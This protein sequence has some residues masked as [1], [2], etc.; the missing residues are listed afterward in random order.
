MSELRTLLLTDIV[1]STALAARLGDADAAALGAA[2]DRVARDLL[3]AWRGRE[4]DKTDGMLMLFDRASDA[5]GCAL[6]YHDALGALPTPIAARAAIH[7]AAIELRANAAH[8]VALGA[9]PLEV[10][11]IAK[12]IAARVM[13]IANGGQTLL[14]AQAR[15]ALGEASA[16]TQDWRVQS[17]GHWRLKGIVDP[18]ELFEVGGAHA[19]FV[20]PPDSAK[21]YRV[22]RRRELWLP[23]RE[24]RHT[25]PAERDDFIGR[26]DALAELVRRLDSG[27]RLVSV[28][29][30]GGS[31]KTRLVTRFAWTWLGEYPG[32]VW[33]CDLSQSR[34]VEGIAHAVAQGLEVRLG[35]DDPV[36]QLGHAIAGR[37]ACLVILDN[38]EQVARHADETLG[39]W[40]DRAADA[41]FVVTTREVLGLAGETTF[42]LAPLPA[43]DATALFVRRAKAARSDFLP[44]ADDE[45]AIPQLVK[46]LDGLPLAIELAAARVRVMPPRAL[47][48][49]M[50]QRFKLLAAAGARHDRQATLRAAFDASWELLTP[51]EKSA[52]AQLSV[53]EGGFSIEAAEAVVDLA[54][55]DAG[56]HWALDVLQSLHDKSFVRS[57]A[58]TRMELLTSVQEYAA[59]HLRTPG[60]FAGSGPVA[61]AAAQARH[62]AHFAAIDTRSVTA[63]H[64]VELD[65]LVQACRRAVASGN[66]DLAVAVLERAWIALELHGPFSA[67]ASLANLVAGLPGSAAQVQARASRVLGAALYAAG[68]PAAA[69]RHFETALRAD[70]DAI[71]AQLNVDLGKI[72][73]GD[74]ELDAA[75]ERFSCA[76]AAAR[77]SGARLVECAALNGLGSICTDQGR[78]DEARAHYKSA[79]RI[80]RD[81]GD[82][83][84]EGGLHGNL[85]NV[86]AV[87][88][89][90]DAAQADYERSL[91]AARETGDRRWEG[92][93][94]SN[95][96]LLNYERG[97]AADA[98]QQFEA[99]LQI[100]REIGHRR[101]EGVALCN[102]GIARQAIGDLATARFDF[103]AAVALARAIG[104]RQ[105]LGQ[106]LGY[107]GLLLARQGEFGAARERLDDG[108]AILRQISS[109]VDLGLLLCARAEAEHLAGDV[110]AA[111]N[112]IGEAAAIAA[113]IG[114][115]S[116]ID[117]ELARTLDRVRALVAAARGGP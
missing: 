42:A 41:R 48:A 71:E 14:T 58:D 28:L 36:V 60:R 77:R 49:R 19:P 115:E 9:K 27:V 26:Q 69:K 110:S 1:D 24:I 63:G 50:D 94:L 54:A 10:D 97:R 107:L 31:G 11:G 39:R 75:N 30:V 56:T 18:V 66:A 79:L 55:D 21:A 32:G 35:R 33:F 109:H 81:A 40:L 46:L 95:L 70:G 22:V 116:A 98:L 106:A 43:P 52:L 99:A 57:V 13:A 102:L 20:T 74:G 51:V 82:R 25:V 93:A 87:L 59:E 47:L 114:A 91:A 62:V 3:R 65:N 53:F 12:P 17:H 88:G 85:G 2:H 23:V 96:G 101:L 111:H 16:H 83:H 117:S 76:L 37:G 7:T 72:A 113:A 86:H 103:E 108:A 104:E 112:A 8:D 100:A 45:A 5:V 67:G 89:Q 44:G 38:F 84:W 92:N 90:T 80:A 64:C 4:I 6:A 61:A 29:G 105:T 15:E 78:Y 68:D 73:A 34:S